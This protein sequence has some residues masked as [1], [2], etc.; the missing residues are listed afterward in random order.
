MLLCDK[1]MT[2]YSKEKNILPPAE[3]ILLDLLIYSLRTLVGESGLG[4]LFMILDQDIS[5]RLI[6]ELGI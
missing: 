5:L 1:K 4:N 3:Q 2:W 6:L